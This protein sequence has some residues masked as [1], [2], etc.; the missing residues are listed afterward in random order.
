LSIHSIVTQRRELFYWATAV[1]TFALGT[2]V[3]DLTAITFNLGYLSSG[4][5]FV[6]VF[7][8]PALAYLFSRKHGVF[9]FW[10][11]YIVTRPLGASFADWIAKPKS[12]GGLGRGDGIVAGVLAVLIVAFV[13]YLSMSKVDSSV[14]QPAASSL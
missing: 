3:G 10:F 7:A 4:L 14:S 5:L 8:V 13:A 6:A 11:A 1:V 12:A 2:A 9:Y